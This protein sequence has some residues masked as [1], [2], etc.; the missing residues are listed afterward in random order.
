MRMEKDSDG[1]R[2]SSARWRIISGLGAPPPDAAFP[3]K[4]VE[5]IIV[6][7]E[8]ATKEAARH[9]KAIKISSHENINQIIKGA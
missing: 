9:C 8:I 3:A 5:E 1:F 4:A 6:N 7:T 2:T